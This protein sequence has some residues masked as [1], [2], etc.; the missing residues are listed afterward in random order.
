[1]ASAG[2]FLCQY[3]E[4]I[5]VRIT[6]KRGVSL[7]GSANQRKQCLDQSLSF[8]SLIK[9]FLDHLLGIWGE[10]TDVRLECRDAS[11]RA[12]KF[13]KKLLIVENDL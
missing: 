12:F 5:S 1:M 3:V 8:R 4:K 10:G 2:S 7:D 13:R 11:G 6:H 9:A